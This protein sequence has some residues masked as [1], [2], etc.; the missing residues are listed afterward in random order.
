MGGSFLYSIILHFLV[1]I[2]LIVQFPTYQE[3]YPVAKEAPIIVDLTKVNITSKTNV[4]PKQKQATVQK[5]PLPP[6]PVAKPTI[7]PKE[8]TPPKPAIKPVQK[9]PPAPSIKPKNEVSKNAAK[10]VENKK[11]VPPLEEKKVKNSSATKQT[12][13]DEFD[14]LFASVEKISKQ[15]KQNDKEKQTE[16]FKGV[17]N[18]AGH[19]IS[20][21]FELTMTELDFISATVRKY[22]NVDPSARGIDSIVVDLKLHLD[23]TGYV[24]RVDFVDEKRYNNDAGYR[25]VADSARR[26]VLICNTLGE[27]SPFRILPQK[28][29]GDFSKWKEMILSFSPLEKN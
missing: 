6:K 4:P 19:N 21:S 22:W 20:D 1:L 8:K 18:G 17:E 26:A 28:H 3:K 12:A 16:T 2:L 29:I 9:T 5:K 13:D 11:T 14:S 15:V 7:K 24:Y 27:D 10:A 25:S 23:K